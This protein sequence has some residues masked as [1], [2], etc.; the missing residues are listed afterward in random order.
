MALTV[1]PNQFNGCTITFTAGGTGAFF[2]H[3]MD[4][5]WGGIA[6]AS[7]DTSSAD[8]TGAMTC[9]FSPKYDPGEL[10][11][12]MRFD[13]TM[14]ETPTHIEAAMVA[15]AETTT[16][17]FRG[18]NLDSWAATGGLTGFEVTGSDQNTWDA[19]ATIKFT[20]EIATTLSEA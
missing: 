17:L 18:A 7:I 3:L 12:S 10:S 20:G 19:T 14:G 9:V 1:W 4:V 16:L 13:G 15:D 6:R 8:T 5:T 2:A 11:V